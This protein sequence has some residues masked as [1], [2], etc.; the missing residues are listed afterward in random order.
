MEN[1]Y[2]DFRIYDLEATLRKGQQN[3]ISRKDL[4]RMM[5]M[6]DRKMRELI[7]K[8]REEGCVILNNQDGKG[9]FL[10]AT[11][12]DIHKQYIQDT[13]RAMAILKRR[14]HIRRILKEAGI[15]V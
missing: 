3:A 6:P 2:S 14:K 5:D 7:E 9:Y 12:E 15:Q 4:A 10:P 11:I 1:Q 13:N 8:A